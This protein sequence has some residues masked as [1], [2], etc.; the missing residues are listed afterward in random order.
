MTLSAPEPLEPDHLVDAFS[1]GKPEL[2]DW[3]KSRAG[4][5]EAKSA[6][7]Y[8]VCEGRRVVGYYCLA[9]GGVMRESV[10]GKFRHG[11]PTSVPVMIMGRLAVDLSCH[12]RGIGSHLLADA[13]RRTVL[14]ARQVG[15]RALL[16]HALDETVLPFYLRH[17]FKPLSAGSRTLF[18]PMETIVSA[19]S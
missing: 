19:L 6:R 18:I 10:P 11:L 12:G 16:V 14:V 9:A 13:M 15:V 4:P 3:L 8:V 7:T 5:S 17:G 2:D 1:C